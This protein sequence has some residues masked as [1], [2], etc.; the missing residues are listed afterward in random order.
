M[1]RRFGLWLVAGVLTLAAAP[2]QASHVA[3]TTYRGTAAG[4][5]TVELDVS[6]DGASITRFVASN[7]RD[8]CGGTLAKAFTGSL[9]IV[10]HAFSSDQADPVRFD[11]SFPASG[12]AAGRLLQSSCPSP[13][14]WT[15]ATGAP[16]GAPQ[17]PPDRTP[18]A[19]E[20]SAG[21]SQ[22][23]R[24]G[25]AIRVR[26]RCPDEPCRVTARGSTKATGARAFRLKRAAAQLEQG[27]S[28]RLQPRLGR[29]AR[30]AARTALLNGRRVRVRVTVIATDAAGNR[31]VRRLSIR[32]HLRR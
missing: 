23:L 9:P 16:A 32:P 26:V 25:G 1:S 13:V 7:V 10:N 24:R 11:G 29:R 15:A 12:Q 2:A 14:S 27:R 17:P 28:V 31:T 20:A 4:G 18:P 19:L 3:G 22:P 8:N 21:R 6:A 5:G 30:R